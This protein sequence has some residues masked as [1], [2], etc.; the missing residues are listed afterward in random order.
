M[1]D[2]LTQSVQLFNQDFTKNKL[3]YGSNTPDF[4]RSE[5]EERADINM[6]AMINNKLSSRYDMSSFKDI[7][8]KLLITYTLSHSIF[9]LSYKQYGE[10]TEEMSKEAVTAAIAYLRCYLPENLPTKEVDTDL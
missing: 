2:L 8:E 4:D 5:Y 1:A 9:S 3:M 7:N 6:V 10:I